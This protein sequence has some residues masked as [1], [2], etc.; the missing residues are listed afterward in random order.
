MKDRYMKDLAWVSLV[1]IL[2]GV[3]VWL[4]GDLYWAAGYSTTP[5]W[6]VFV[7]GGVFLIAIGVA[8]W[9]YLSRKARLI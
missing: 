9:A 1:L 4:F 3:A 5:V 6:Y 7:Y 8:E 2:L